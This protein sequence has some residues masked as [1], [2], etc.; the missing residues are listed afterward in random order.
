MR[1]DGGTAADGVYSL[2]HNRA[3]TNVAF[4]FDETARLEPADD[5]LTVARGQL[6]S[7]P[8]FFFDVDVDADRDFTRALAAVRDPIDFTALV[9]T[10]GVRRTSPQLWTTLDWMH[11]DFRGPSRRSS[12]CSTS[13][14]TATTDG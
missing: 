12:A 3:H 7:Y 8:N 4:M 6:G 14:A 2:V 13:T 5:T 1:D 11:D 10:W 9:D